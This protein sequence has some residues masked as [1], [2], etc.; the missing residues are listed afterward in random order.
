MQDEVHRFAISYHRQI[1][2]KGLYVSILDN[3]DGI[4]AKRKNM[5]LK[6]YKT[7]G[8]LKQCTVDEL[9]EIVPRNVAINLI[10]ILNEVS[11]ENDKM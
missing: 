6:K 5:L 7:I 11:S 9:S 1:R 4:G 8:K 10:K 3:V 2:S